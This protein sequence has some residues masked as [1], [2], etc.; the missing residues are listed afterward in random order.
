[1]SPD[2]LCFES[3]HIHMWCHSSCALQIQLES[4]MSSSS[5]LDSS[6]GYLGRSPVTIPQDSVGPSWAF[7]GAVVH[8]EQVRSPGLLGTHSSSG[9]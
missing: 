7:Q 1:M 2:T 3:H 4:V 5:I 6:L 9:D 8:L